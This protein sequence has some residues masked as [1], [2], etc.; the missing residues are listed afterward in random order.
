[1]KLDPIIETWLQ[2]AYNLGKGGAEAVEYH[3]NQ[4][5]KKS[6]QIAD[7]VTRRVR[8]SLHKIDGKGLRA[9]LTR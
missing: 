6:P 8:T 7:A 2:A 3:I 9:P 5:E 4:L 1:M